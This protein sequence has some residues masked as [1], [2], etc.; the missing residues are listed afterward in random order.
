MRDITCNQRR[1]VKKKGNQD[2]VQINNIYYIS[3]KLTFFALCICF[4]ILGHKNYVLRFATL[5]GGN[6][7]PGHYNE[8]HQSHAEA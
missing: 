5:L 3:M 4:H 1:D 2:C 8:G 7:I 6:N